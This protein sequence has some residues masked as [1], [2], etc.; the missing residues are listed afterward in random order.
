MFFKVSVTL[1]R[2][3]REVMGCGDRGW[4]ISC[5]KIWNFGSCDFGDHVYA[6][7][8]AAFECFS[9]PIKKQESFEFPY[10]VRTSIKKLQKR[11]EIFYRL[12]SNLQRKN[13]RW[14]ELILLLLSERNKKLSRKGFAHLTKGQLRLPWYLDLSAT[15][16]AENSSY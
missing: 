10:N 1:L 6:P 5:L 16:L 11:S 3:P 12:V 2:H 15:V 9:A 13:N 4:T 7:K 14:N 8:K